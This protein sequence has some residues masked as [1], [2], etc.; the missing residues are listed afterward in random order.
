MNCGQCSGAASGGITQGAARDAQYGRYKFNLRRGRRPP[1][2]RVH[3]RQDDKGVLAHEQNARES[4]RK[5]T[6]SCASG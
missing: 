5:S 4:S 2:A 6:S 1:R 3:E